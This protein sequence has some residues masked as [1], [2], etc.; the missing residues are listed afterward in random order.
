MHSTWM[1]VVMTMYWFCAPTT[2]SLGCT[3]EY[4]AR[5]KKEV[6]IPVIIVGK[7]GY[8][9][10]AEKVLDNALFISIHGKRLNHISA[11]RLINRAMQG[12]TEAKRKSPHVLRHS[13][14][15]HLLDHGADIQSVSEMLGH[16][17]LSTTQIY[18]HVSVDRL[19]EAYKKAHPKA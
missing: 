15:T 3:V 14:A 1:L 8:P 18:P 19:K 6:N 7:L 13:F 16:A 5:L 12:I 4:V 10:I 17:S 9:E 2:L 11:Y